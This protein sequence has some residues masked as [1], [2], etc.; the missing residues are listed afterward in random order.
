MSD[1]VAM[2]YPSVTKAGP[3][4]SIE[5]GGRL[6]KVPKPIGVALVLYEAR[7]TV[8]IEGALLPVMAGNAVLLRG[9]AETAA[10][11]AAYAMIV[12]DALVDVGLPL[13]LAVSIADPD[14]ALVRALLKRRDAIDILIPRGSA[15]LIDYCRSS[16][17]I[18]V[19]A[20]AGSV[21]HLYVHR[22]AD[23]ELAATITLDSKIVEPDACNSLEMAL[24]DE[25]IWEKYLEHL[26]RGA[27]ETRRCI[28]L[29]LGGAELDSR[30]AD[31]S[32]LLRIEPLEAHD[33]GR[34]FPDA[35]ICARPVAGLG[36]ALQHI[37]EHG[38]SHTEGILSDDAATVDA[39]V[40]EVDAAVI[41]INGSLRLHDSGALGFGADFTINTGRLHARG[42]I[43][44]AALLS[45]SWVV[46]ACGRT[47]PDR[48]T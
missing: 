34:E 14:R 28:T 32:D 35:T 20:S 38:S 15:S 8:G 25:E 18:P 4:M 45:S 9:G 41:V 19:F 27:K 44:V 42:P 47:G 12:R 22:S 10:T 21:N 17:Q 23:P 5:G 46:D 11:D 26:V 31:P 36:A 40:S 1:Q 29:R 13:G 37:K 6:R 43:N 33:I 7:P 2:D 48:S 30:G 16:S 24:V 39:F 3:W